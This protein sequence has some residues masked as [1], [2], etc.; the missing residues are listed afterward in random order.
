MPPP[1]SSAPLDDTTTP[2]D[3]SS[4]IN[5]EVCVSPPTTSTSDI[6]SSPVTLENAILNPQVMDHDHVRRYPLRER[7][8]PDRLGF[9]KS[10]SNVTYTISD[11]ISYHRLSKAHLAFA[12]QLS[13]V[14]IPSHF[15][16][17]LGDPNWKAAMEEEMKALQKKFY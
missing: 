13:F 9:F 12:L 17:A 2:S 15:Q 11:F 14:S 4:T 5:P 10:S 7:R 8:E 6:D 16:E 1:D 3:D